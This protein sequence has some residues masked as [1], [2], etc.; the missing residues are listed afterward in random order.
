M[1]TTAQAPTQFIDPRLLDFLKACDPGHAHHVGRWVKEFA[2]LVQF[3]WKPDELL[4]AAQTGYDYTYHLMRGSRTNRKWRSDAK[5]MAGWH[6]HHYRQ[7][8]AEQAGLSFEEFI[9]QW[10]TFAGEG[11]RTS[12]RRMAAFCK[13]LRW[14]IDPSEAA[15]AVMR[16][17]QYR[18]YVYFRSR[19]IDA[20]TL[21][22]L[23]LTKERTYVMNNYRK[24]FIEA[25]R[26]GATIDQLRAALDKNKIRELALSLRHQ[27]RGE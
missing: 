19:D 4:C 25:Y 22:R 27:K 9:T 3:G 7:M 16:Y 10:R 11:Y 6:R 14:G 15:A 13:A 17:E 20:D 12:E 1:E 5:P 23:L 8:K 2:A 24:W 26:R 21:R 18:I